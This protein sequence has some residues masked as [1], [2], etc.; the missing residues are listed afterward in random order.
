MKN[1]IFF[2]LVSVCFGL[3]AQDIEDV[4]RYSFD[5]TQGT[6]RYQGLS[7]AF[8]ALGGDLSAINSNAASSAV[9]NNS[10]FTFTGTNYNRNNDATYFG[11]FRNGG[12]WLGWWS[13]WS[14]RP[15]RPTPLSKIL[16][17]HCM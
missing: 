17:M 9:F 3:Q 1:S 15:S 10:Q 2:I 11:Q 13:F 16:R 6:A 8:T 14:G 5:N 4:L 7:G 12:S